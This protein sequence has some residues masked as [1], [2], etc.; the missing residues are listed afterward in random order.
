MEDPLKQLLLQS[1]LSYEDLLKK[2]E[3]YKNENVIKSNSNANVPSSDERKTSTISHENTIKND[4]VINNNT[5]PNNEEGANSVSTEENKGVICVN[6][7][8]LSDDEIEDIAFTTQCE[9]VPPSIPPV[10]EQKKI[11]SD[12]DDILVKSVISPSVAGKNSKGIKILNHFKIEKIKKPK[13]SVRKST[14]SNSLSEIQI[15]NVNI[16]NTNCDIN[17]TKSK[18]SKRSSIISV[19]PTCDITKND[20]YKSERKFFSAENKDLLPEKPFAEDL[21]GRKHDLSNKSDDKFNIKRR[22]YYE[23]EELNTIDILDDLRRIGGGKGFERISKNEATRHTNFVRDYVNYNET[24]QN[25][26]DSLFDISCDNQHVVEKVI[27]FK[28]SGD[29]IEELNN[30]FDDVESNSRKILPC[31]DTFVKNNEC[32]RIIANTKKLFLKTTDES[33]TNN[34]GTKATN[35]NTKLLDLLPRN[36][37]NC[38]EIQMD[39]LASSK[40]CRQP[41]IIKVVDLAK[42]PVDSFSSH[43]KNMNALNPVKRLE[44]KKFN[45]NRLNHITN[46]LL[47]KL[48]KNTPCATPNINEHDSDGVAFKIFN[49]VGGYQS[50]EHEHEEDQL[51]IPKIN[52]ATTKPDN[53]KENLHRSKRTLN[54]FSPIDK[55]PPEKVNLLKNPLDGTLKSLEY[56]D[57]IKPTKTNDVTKIKGWKKK[58]FSTETNLT[59]LISEH[60]NSDNSNNEILQTSTEVTHPSLKSSRVDISNTSPHSAFTSDILDQYLSENSSLNIS[61]E[62]PKLDA[63]QTLKQTYIDIKFPTY[64]EQVRKPIIQ[65]RRNG[66]KPKTVAEKRR[67]EEM[68]MNPVVSFLENIDTT[69][70][71]LC[72]RETL[73]IKKKLISQDVPFTRGSFRTAVKLT[74]TESVVLYDGKRLQ[75]PSS[76]ENRVIEDIIKPKSKSLS[77]AKLKQKPR[78]LQKNVSSRIF[79]NPKEWKDVQVRLPKIFLEV[80]PQIGKRIH[81]NVEH[82]VKFNNE[83]LNA[84]RVN[85][86]LSTLKTKDKP[87]T[88]QTFTFPIPYKNNRKTKIMKRRIT[89]DVCDWPSLTCHEPDHM[90]DSSVKEVVNKLLDYCERLDEIKDIIPEVDTRLE[91]G[92]RNSFDVV[93]KI[94]K[95]TK[96]DTVAFSKTEKEMRRLNC[97]LLSIPTSDELSSKDPCKNEHCALGCICSNFSN[98]FQQSHCGR[99]QCMFQCT[100]DFKSQSKSNTFSQGIINRLQDEATRNLA[101]EEKE[102]TQTLIKTNNQL[103]LVGDSERRKRKAKVPKRYTDF[104]ESEL[105]DNGVLTVEPEITLDVPKPKE[106]PVL[107]C[108]NIIIPPCSV[109]LVKYNFSEIIPYCMIHSLYKCYCRKQTSQNSLLSG[110]KSS[111]SMMPVKFKEKLPVKRKLTSNKPFEEQSNTSIVPHEEGSVTNSEQTKTKETAKKKTSVMPIKFKERVVPVEERLISN[112]LFEEQTNT[113]IVPSVAVAVT[114]SKQ[115]K[116]KET[117]IKKRKPPYNNQ[118]SSRTKGITTCLYT[119]RNKS[120]FHRENIERTT[121]E[122]EKKLHAYISENEEL[123]LQESAGCPPRPSPSQD[124]IEVIESDKT[125]FNQEDVCIKKQNWNVEVS[126][127]VTTIEITDPVMQEKQAID[128]PTEDGNGVKELKLQRRNTKEKQR[129]RK[130]D[131]SK[132][133]INRKYLEFLETYSLQT[134]MLPWTQLMSKYE[135]GSYQLWYLLSNKKSLVTLTENRKRPSVMHFNLKVMPY[136]SMAYLHKY[137][138]VVQYVISKKTPFGKSKDQI[139]ALV[140][141]TQEGIWKICGLCEKNQGNED[142]RF[143]ASIIEFYE[144]VQNIMKYTVNEAQLNKPPSL[145][146]KRNFMKFKRYFTSKLLVPDT[147][148][149]GTLNKEEKIRARLPHVQDF[150]WMVVPIGVVFSQLCF[151]RCNFVIEYDDIIKAISIAENY[152]TTVVIKLQRLN[153]TYRHNKFGIYCDSNVPEKVFIGPYLKNENH[154]LKIM[155]FLN[156]SLIESKEFFNN[157]SFAK[158]TC[159]WYHQ[160]SDD[161]IDDDDNDVE[162]IQVPEPLI[163]LTCDSDN[164]EITQNLAPQSDLK[165]V[166]NLNDVDEKLVEETNSTSQSEYYSPVGVPRYIITNIPELGYIPAYLH[167]K[168][169]DVILCPVSKTPRRFSNWIVAVTLIRRVMVTKLNLV[170]STFK[171]EVSIAEHVNKSKYKLLNKN[172]LNGY[173]IAGEFGVRYL[174]TVTSDEFKSFNI[175]GPEKV[176]LLE[177]RETKLLQIIA[178]QISKILTLKPSTKLTGANLLK[179]ITDET[180]AEVK[181]LQKESDK[182]VEELRVL[183]DRKKT[184]ITNCKTLVGSLPQSLRLEG[185]KLLD[186]VLEGSVHNLRKVNDKIINIVDEDDDNKTNGKDSSKGSETSVLGNRTESTTHKIINCSAIEPPFIIKDI[187][188]AAAVSPISPTPV[189]PKS[190]SG[191]FSAPNKKSTFVNLTIAKNP[192]VKRIVNT[193]KPFKHVLQTVPHLTK[194]NIPRSPSNSL[195]PLNNTTQTTTTVSNTSFTLH[196]AKVKKSVLPTSTT[197]SVPVENRNV[198]SM[199]TLTSAPRTV[200]YIALKNGNKVNYLKVRNNVAVVANANTPSLIKYPNSNR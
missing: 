127:K 74:G 57:A 184:L 102:F 14:N 72:I 26:V 94:I 5:I 106:D 108:G 19:P 10:K 125:E 139:L 169:L 97:K 49:V 136:Q 16:V 174:G 172:F 87:F 110:K 155:I 138:N 32:D 199:A 188:R 150:K 190:L 135:N 198:S 115:M 176:R 3:Q 123:I 156:D 143:T 71:K 34:N 63:E 60:I 21:N 44:S 147:S 73:K 93:D 56:K 13:C 79:Y 12:T 29:L 112:K 48:Q 99:Y 153:S 80:T 114:N 86:A 25:I 11:S 67:M 167:D 133:E 37:K 76:K 20:A 144:D 92:K 194:I 128:F 170:P 165:S 27:E 38:N 17:N 162:L 196:T 116:T 129:N 131:L 82:F 137:N 187:T 58:K 61:Y 118:H 23:H 145:K 175:S 122:L 185:E 91:E 8:I 173:Y 77:F 33:V 178:I 39:K 134:R 171:L 45:T 100:C 24:K 7:E 2:L 75:V 101:K 95:K 192:Q 149:N 107:L 181:R 103:I 43:K 53:S 64:P 55:K 166:E 59:D 179:F 70:K 117:V 154:D 148:N 15:S 189:H 83:I 191:N 177:L 163:D 120:S 142:E 66:L 119:I 62:L 68:K 52:I 69:Q 81:P 96:T 31:L 157:S 146:Q 6:V 126:E 54:I 200:N 140:L 40:D 89:S 1:G 18:I 42:E 28:N 141:E 50:P 113:S 30:L 104:I 41:D 124:T 183:V 160:G 111:P 195:A 51:R 84:D 151:E 65:Q 152:S 9:K 121:M 4:S 36:S 109:K 182:Y 105:L 164:D 98:L 85:F 161:T 46:V 22:K 132:Y 159:L 47:Q 78:L 180:F 168:G 186:N 88:S 158:N 197:L 90:I 35:N 130:Q 193:A